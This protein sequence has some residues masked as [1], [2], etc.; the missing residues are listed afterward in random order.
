[1][2]DSPGPPAE[3]KPHVNKEYEDPHYHDEDD[4][5]PPVD[6]DAPH[7]THA[8]GARSRR[9]ACRRPAGGLRTIDPLTFRE[10]I[11]CVPIPSSGP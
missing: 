3:L 1:M 11:P 9:A 7:G 5:T 4:V 6:D 2:A 8:P 10:A